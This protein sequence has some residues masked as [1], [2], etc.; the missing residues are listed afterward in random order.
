MNALQGSLERFLVTVSL[1]QGRI[2]GKL[3]ALRGAAVKQ[4][5]F[6]GSRCKVDRP[7][8]VTLGERFIAEDL[9]YLKIVADN[10]VLQ[11]GDHVSATIRL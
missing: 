5:V 6:I 10:A 7:W 3:L 4:K 2:R 9:V 11:F 8:C 1:I